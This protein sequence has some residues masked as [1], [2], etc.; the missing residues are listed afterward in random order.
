MA[1]AIAGQL[2]DNSVLAV[3]SVFMNLAGITYMCPQAISFATAIVAGVDLGAN[4]S[5]RAANTVAVGIALDVGYG[6]AAAALILTVLR[7]LICEAFIGDLSVQEA[8]YYNLP[9]M[10]LYVIVDSSKCITLN[11]LRSVG[12]PFVTVLGNVTACVLI[13]LPLGYHLTVTRQGGIA[14][15]W[16]SM[17]MAWL[18]ATVIYASVLITT[19]WDVEAKAA[20]SRTTNSSR[21][22]ETMEELDA[23]LPR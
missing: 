19:D 20:V 17:S 6:I 8:V 1:V 21:R 7:R 4:A 23:H 16:F 11:C 3:H 18:C 5:G 22:I 14:A 12:R 2:H 9:V 15:L 13:M 10:A